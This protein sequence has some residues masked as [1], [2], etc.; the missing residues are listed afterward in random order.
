MYCRVLDPEKARS[1]CGE[2]FDMFGQRR[3]LTLN[4]MWTQAAAFF[5]IARLLPNP[6]AQQIPPLR[7]FKDPILENI[8]CGCSCNCRKFGQPRFISPLNWIVNGRPS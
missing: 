8:F 5:F 2:L 3:A 4:R 1:R 6:A 7:H